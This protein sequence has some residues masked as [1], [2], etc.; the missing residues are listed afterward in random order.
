MPHAGAMYRV[1]YAVVGNSADAADAVQDAFARLWQTRTSLAGVGNIKAYCLTAARRCALDIAVRSA[2][3]AELSEGVHASD[4][5]HDRAEWAST[6]EAVEKLIERLPPDQ[7]EVIRLR[8]VG[9]MT[10][11][12]IAGIAGVSPDNARQLLSRGRRRLKELYKKLIDR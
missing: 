11:E 9:D 8:S 1:A 6:L 10:M 2:P 5:G 7:R 4:G 12:E 3:P